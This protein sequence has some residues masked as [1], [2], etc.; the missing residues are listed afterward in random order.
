MISKN[1]IE[2]SVKDTGLGISQEDQSKLFKTFGKVIDKDNLALNAQ[3]I[4]LGLLISNRLAYQISENKKAINLTSEI[5]AGSTFTFTISYLR[6]DATNESFSIPSDNHI[7]TFNFAGTLKFFPSNSAFFPNPFHAPKDCKES[8]E[9]VYYDQTIVSKKQSEININPNR[10]SIHEDNK[11]YDKFSSFSIYSNNIMGQYKEKSGSQHDSSR[12]VRSIF[13]GEAG[14]I[15]IR[16][17]FDTEVGLEKKLEKFAIFFRFKT[18]KCPFALI[19]DDND[20]NIL[21]LSQQLQRIGI[22]SDSALNGIEG[23]KKIKEK[24]HSSCCNF[25]KIIFLDV[26]MPFKDGVDT[27]KEIKD[28][29]N[30]NHH[31]NLNVVAVTGYNKSNTRVNKMVEMGADILMKPISIEVILLCVENI[32]RKK[33]MF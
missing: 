9:N 29:Y 7:G 6:S 8:R 5:G 28:I 24:I 27:M 12:N 22:K 21:A 10:T 1:E 20:F 2:I 18:C 31:T 15:D 32:F 26:E 4:G 33:L 23:V 25:Y 30:E 3:G 19:V 13:I 11:I 16:E 14:S 17:F